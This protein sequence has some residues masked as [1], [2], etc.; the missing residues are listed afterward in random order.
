MIV[1]AQDY[2]EWCLEI[3][4]IQL[5]VVGEFEMMF[6]VIVDGDG[7]ARVLKLQG[8][9]ASVSTTGEG[10][11]PKVSQAEGWQWESQIRYLGKD[12][13]TGDGGVPLNL[14]SCDWRAW[15]S[16][17][18]VFHDFTARQR[19]SWTAEYYLI[20]TDILE[21]WLWQILNACVLPW[22]K[23][24]STGKIQK[25]SWFCFPKRRQ[26]SLCRQELW[27]T[28]SRESSCS[29]FKQIQN[30]IPEVADLLLCKHE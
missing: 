5:S 21:L 19:G 20:D 9:R 25:L 10:L 23:N 27:M 8:N 11:V 7:E 22:I 4:F 24:L 13:T 28:P 29:K 30:S 17:Q 1:S 2:V 18:Y 3:I 6:S 15:A 12:I 14:D 16:A 26:V